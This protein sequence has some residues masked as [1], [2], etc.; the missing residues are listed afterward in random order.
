MK[1]DNFDTLITG[2]RDETVDP[3]IVD[4]AASRV[5]DRLFAS[6]ASTGEPK[7]AGSLRTC[8][9]FQ[10][11]IPAYLNRTLT[12]A[13]SLLLVDHT[14]ECV[15]CRREL[16]TSRSG[17]VRVLTR[18]ETVSNK[19][20]P[21][22]RWSIAAMVAAGVGLGTWG[23]VNSLSVPAGARATVQS[24]SGILYQVADRSS[25]PVYSGRQLSERQIVRTAKGS[26]AML[27][28]ADG[29]L[30]EMNERSELSISRA[31]RGTTIA[32]DR[33]NVIVHAAKQRTGAL[34]VKTADCE[35]MVKGTIFAVTRGTKGSRVSVVEGSV[36]V[37]QG[38]TSQMLKPGDQV[39]TSASVERVP[40]KDEIAWSQD[41]AKYLAILGELSGLQKQIEKI[42]G[43]GL[44]T[45][46][47]LLD[48][49]PENTLI[50]AA[51]PNLG[52]TL[53]QANQLFEDRIQASP[54][55]K[56]WWSRQGN[57]AAQLKDMVQKFR[58]IS[59]YLGDEIVL[60]YSSDSGKQGGSP[61]IMAETKRDGLREYLQSEI[62][63]LNG[64]SGVHAVEM[65]DNPSLL[66]S[67]G[68]EGA[69]S[70]KVYMA[71]GIIAMSPEPV[72]VQNLAER[73][74]SSVA[75]RDGGLQTRVRQAYQSGASWLFCADLG[76][77]HARNEDD[78]EQRNAVME[79]SGL[80]GVRYLL[81][82]RKEVNGQVKNQATLAFGGQ[83]QGLAAWL[84]A[85]GPMSTLDFV[86]PDASLATS[87]VINNPGALIGQ[88]IAQGEAKNPNLGQEISDFQNKLGINIQNDIA[89]SLGGELT[90]AI[91]GPL[92]P[93]PSWKL[94]VEV[95]SP[96]R[97]QWAIDKLVNGFNQQ[98][99]SPVKLQLTKS[100]EGSRT[101]YTLTGV[102]GK[103]P[104]E[105]DYVFVDSYLL[106]AANRN[107]LNTAIQNRSTGYTLTRSEKFRSVVPQDAN[108]NFSAIV[109]H[110]VSGLVGPL[111]D[112]LK[113]MGGISSEQKQAMDTLKANSA[114]GLI[115]AYGEPNR[116]TVAANGSLF[117]FS[118]DSF[119]LPKVIESLMRHKQTQ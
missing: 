2:L 85:P 49:I 109:Y 76:R 32:L 18:P 51:I 72:L 115:Y 8:S 103:I 97:L 89:D 99:A 80:N 78:D 55:L 96:D 13:K 106:A 4:R 62:L 20:S 11:L 40:V 101:F 64:K 117:G 58:T 37:D 31:A 118:L 82:E 19:V 81:F 98:T 93:V 68:S 38:A 23:M 6:A 48:Y 17:N 12:P 24:V 44:R 67:N 45:S 26:T 10:A 75:S 15:E 87:F 1:T 105:I 112:G 47:K 107:L 86:S 50:F 56:E 3:A 83:R 91:D 53:T 9:D 79:N 119:A 95:Y 90:F 102:G 74:H 36:K 22:T 84:A 41:A 59:D 63:T 66:R 54:V 100:Q 114:P 94:A 110:N 65:V 69:S 35:V 108:S 42:P 28:L 43:T 61:I 16:E 5:R 46:S 92:V 33:G 104:A 116:I 60:A 25:T 52:A 7:T 88:L 14:H 27:K 77:L 29:S 21:V 39:A 70:M 113:S 34:Y 111:A 30:V 71:N 73:L 57:N